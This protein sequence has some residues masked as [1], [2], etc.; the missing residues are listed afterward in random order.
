MTIPNERT[1]ALR[2]ARDFLRRLL[3]P[4]NGGIKRVPKEVR[5]EARSVLKHYP[6]DYEIEQITECK[7]CSKILGAMILV[8][9]DI[10]TDSGC[11]SKKRQHKSKR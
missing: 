1:N 6:A 11:G 3:S 4:Y 10:Q 9:H 8:K 7:K 2:M 5:Q